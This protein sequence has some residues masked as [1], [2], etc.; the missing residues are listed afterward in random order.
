V[1]TS[2]IAEIRKIVSRESTADTE[3]VSEN[4]LAE[5]GTGCT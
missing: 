2:I 3:N 4:P 5:E 1:A